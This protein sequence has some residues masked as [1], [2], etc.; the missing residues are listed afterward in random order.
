MQQ[1]Y[2]RYEVEDFEVWQ[3]LYIRQEQQLQNQQV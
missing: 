2:E 3:L 1:D